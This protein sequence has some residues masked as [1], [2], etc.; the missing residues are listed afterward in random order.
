M[1][2]RSLQSARDKGSRMAAL[3]T[4]PRSAIHGEAPAGI[5][6]TDDGRVEWG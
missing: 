6:R 2:I 5:S 1:T 4:P 3:P